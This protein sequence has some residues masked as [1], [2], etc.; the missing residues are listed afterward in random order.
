[1]FIFF[2][3]KICPTLCKPSNR[4]LAKHEKRAAARPTARTRVRGWSGASA[5]CRRHGARGGVRPP[6]GLGKRLAGRTATQ[7]SGVQNVSQDGTCQVKKQEQKQII[8]VFSC[9]L[10][11]ASKSVFSSFVNIVESSSHVL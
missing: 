6:L 11:F 7:R 4:S 10:C 5:G 3:N 8:M 2:K 1:M 9:L